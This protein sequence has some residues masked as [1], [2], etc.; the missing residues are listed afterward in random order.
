MT[1]NFQNIPQNL[2]VPLFYA[3]VDNSQANTAL[4]VQR[5]LIIGQK[6]GTG[7]GVIDGIALCPSLNE[8][9]RLAGAASFICTMVDAYR[10]NDPSG[11]LWVATLHDDPA[12]VAAVGS[13]TFTAVATAA[14]TYVV[15]IGGRRYA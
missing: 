4:A 1:I 11:E 6:L 9:A 2:R 10:Q 5:T 8:A 12:S 7:A 14:G 3:E 15:Y 13:I